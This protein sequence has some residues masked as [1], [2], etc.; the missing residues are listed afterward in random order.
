MPRD[1][2]GT[3]FWKRLMQYYIMAYENALNCEKSIEIEHNLVNNR[4]TCETLSIL[5]FSPRY[6][7]FD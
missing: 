4:K 6:C 7:R 1:F 5:F 2:K 3:I